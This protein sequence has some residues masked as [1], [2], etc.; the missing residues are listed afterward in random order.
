MT[1]A[2][3][4][5]ARPLVAVEDLSPA[6]VETFLRVRG[7]LRTDWRENLYSIWESTTERASLMLPFDRSYRDFPAR[8]RDALTTIAD[9]YELRNDEDLALEIAGARSDIL[10]V[11]ADQAT[12][13]GSIPL[14]EAQNLLTGVNQMLSAAACSAIRPRA[15]NQGRRPDAVKEFLAEE[16]RM[17]HTLRGSF[18]LT[19][20]AR[21]DEEMSEELPVLSG[22]ETAAIGSYTRRVMTT[23]ATGLAASR[24]LL[25]EDQPLELDEAVQNG[26][27]AELIDSIDRMSQFPGLRALDVSFRW[28]PSQ[29][30]PTE[31]VG[32]VVLRRPHPERVQLVREA[33]RRR[34]VVEQDDVV[35]QVVRLERAEGQDEGVVVVDGSLGRTRRRVKMRLAG[36]D[37]RLALRAHDERRPV[38][39]SGVVVLEKRSWWLEPPVRIRALS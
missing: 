7:W 3:D 18:V 14:A 38:V 33:L 6:A 22:S 13:D 19:I 8:L 30:Q 36:D 21:H 5:A 26:A 28:S 4:F 37:Y 23:L 16:V 12:V 20:L 11:R 27:S 25:E 35:G 32:R 1:T 2:R 9:V 15:F 10:L 34:P 39:A 17:G 29:P 24:D 31:A